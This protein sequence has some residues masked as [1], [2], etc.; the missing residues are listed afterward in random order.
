MKTKLFVDTLHSKNIAYFS[1]FSNFLWIFPSAKVSD[2]YL[3]FICFYYI[4]KSTYTLYQFMVLVFLDSWIEIL[5]PRRK[6][7]IALEILKCNLD[8]EN[9]MQLLHMIF[10]DNI[11]EQFRNMFNVIRSWSWNQSDSLKIVYLH[12]SEIPVC[13]IQNRVWNGN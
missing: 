9:I 12:S 7:I 8:H 5:H 11:L 10:I 3:G 6:L 13:K 2:L 1:R 4:C